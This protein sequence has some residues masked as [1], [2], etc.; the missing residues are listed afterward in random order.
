VNKKGTIFQYSCRAFIIGLLVSCACLE[1]VGI[2]VKPFLES[3]E[4]K[5]DYF[6]SAAMEWQWP[7]MR[8]ISF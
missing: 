1:A 7:K 6:V 4:R 8:Q 3:G 2:N 5:N